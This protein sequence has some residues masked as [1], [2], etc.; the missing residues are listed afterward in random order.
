MEYMSHG[1]LVISLDFEIHWGVSDKRSVESYKEN[2]DNV[3]TVVHRLLQ[4]YQERKIHCT[5]ATVGMLFCRSKEELFAFVPPQHRPTYLKKSVSNY[6]VAEQAGKDEASDPYHFA[7]GLISKILSTPGQEI[8][9][10]TFSHYYCLEPGQTKEQFYYDV[11]AAKQVAARVGVD[12]KS[13]IFPANQFHPD[14]LEKCREQGL[15]CYRGNYPS[16]I[17][18]FQAKSKE[19]FYKRLL[20]LIDTYL[21][22]KG[23]RVVT[24]VM[25]NGILNI[26]ASCFLRPYNKKLSFVEWLR[27]RRMKNEMTA[28]AK[29]K[30]IYHLWWHP[31]NFGSSIE[32]NF[33]I[34]EKLLDHFAVLKAKY[35]MQS[36]SMA[37]ILDSFVRD[38]ERSTAN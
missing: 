2:L 28:A 38:Q 33:K 19:G 30:R 23:A 26:P 25:E 6:M 1:T 17:Y 8:A 36:F 27:V 4:I 31:H 9:T 10:H 11:I 18:Q 12:I 16:W 13:I 14:Y 37:E 5:W 21:P 32:Q 24:P 20:R 29:R 3:P 34:L 35:N 22:L 7:S 15:K